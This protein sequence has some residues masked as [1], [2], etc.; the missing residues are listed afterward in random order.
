VSN[1]VIRRPLRIW[2]EG[3]DAAAL[4]ALG[5]GD[6]EVL[7]LPEPSDAAMREQDL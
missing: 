2:S 5:T 7:R 4:E 6:A 1:H 3:S